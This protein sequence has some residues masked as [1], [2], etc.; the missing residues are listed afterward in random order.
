MND[1]NRSINNSAGL[2]LLTLSL[3]LVPGCIASAIKASSAF[4]NQ[5][6]LERHDTRYRIRVNP[7]MFYHIESYRDVRDVAAL[8]KAAVPSTI[9]K[10][11][12]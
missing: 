8:R 9:Q 12:V 2:I 4:Y 1:Y 6:I 5:V 11:L 3:Y 7:S 10:E